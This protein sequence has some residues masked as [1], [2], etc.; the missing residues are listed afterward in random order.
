[1]PAPIV[2][3]EGGR[4]RSGKSV[5]TLKKM[6][7]KA[8]LKTSGK[9]STLTRRA[10]KAKLMKGGVDAKFGVGDMVVIKGMPG[11]WKVVSITPGEPFYTVVNSNGE[12]YT[13]KESNIS[14]S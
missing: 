14:R 11:G 8:G 9:K 6:L 1:M 3:Q 13:T 2:N 4:R 12:Q 10:K 7:K 5:K